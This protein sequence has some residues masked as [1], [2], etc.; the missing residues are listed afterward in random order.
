MEAHAL[1]LILRH[2]IP[3]VALLV[4]VGELGF[5]TG[6][7]VE[8]ALLL[9][10]AYAVH[11]LPMLVAAVAVIAAGDLL[12][13]TLLHVIVR[14]GG[15][16]LLDRFARRHAERGAGFLD[17][18]RRRLGGHDAAVVFVVRLLPM[19]R[20][21]VSIGTGLI[22]IRF[23][24]FLLGAAP[25]ALL[26]SGAPLVVGYAFSADAQRVA[27]RYAAFTHLGIALLPAVGLSTTGVVWL[28][29]ARP[30]RATLLRGRAIFGLLAV[31]ALGGYAGRLLWTNNWRIEHGSGALP[32]PVLALWAAAMATTAGLL[33]AFS[34]LDA[35]VAAVLRERAP[36]ARHRLV[37]GA[38]GMLVWVGLLATAGGIPV[39]LELRYPAL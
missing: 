12:G 26:W 31:A 23:R 9:T 22:R 11:S 3:L 16:R 18:W 14:T 5:P 29:H 10:G 38:A 4:C 19:V 32:T 21:Y 35:H 33:L 8:V 1:D 17:G 24:S 2:G 13:T 27:A 25:A 37:A 34:L 6:I 36:E 30:A 39:L 15:V 7:P 28:R 20:M